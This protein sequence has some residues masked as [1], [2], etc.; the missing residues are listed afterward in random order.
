[1]AEIGFFIEIRKNRGF[2]AAETELDTVGS[3]A[4]ERDQSRAA[5]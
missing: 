3:L 1:M 4:L 2:G 5:C